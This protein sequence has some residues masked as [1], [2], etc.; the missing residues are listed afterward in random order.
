MPDL[1]DELEQLKVTI[2]LGD[3]EY[4]WGYNEAIDDAK[5]ILSQK[6]EPIECSNLRCGSQTKGYHCKYCGMFSDR[7]DSWPCPYA[8]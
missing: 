3:S 1:S 4:W 8:N 7:N 5:V 2:E 6:H